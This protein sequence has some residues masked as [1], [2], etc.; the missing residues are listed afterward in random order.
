LRG[1]LT[2]KH[3][4]VPELMKHTKFEATIPNILHATDSGLYNTPAPEFALYQHAILPLNNII[5]E[6]PEVILVTE[7]NLTLSYSGYVLALSKGHAAFV[8]A[9][10]KVEIKDAV[11]STY[12]RV[13]VPG[14]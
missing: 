8:C 2:N 3:I 10:T 6:G 12:F 1:G 7:G 14:V 4:D 11:N 9:N 5:T 13:V